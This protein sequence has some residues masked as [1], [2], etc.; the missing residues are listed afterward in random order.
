MTPVNASIL[1]ERKRVIP[2]MVPNPNLCGPDRPAIL[3]PHARHNSASLPNFGTIV[4]PEL[5]W[6]P[7]QGRSPALL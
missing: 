6:I 1:I 5:L 2:L 3:R 7:G 4:L